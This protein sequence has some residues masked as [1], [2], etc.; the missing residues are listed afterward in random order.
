MKYFLDAI[1]NLKNEIIKMSELAEEMVR[2]S[3]EGLINREPE[4]LQRVYEIEKEVNQMEIKIDN[5]CITMLGMYQPVAKD[6]RFITSAM[7]INNDLERI[8]D[9]AVNIAKNAEF[10]IKQPQLKPYIDLPRMC[11]ITRKMLLDSI[12]SFIERDINLARD[13]LKRDELVD[14][15]NNQIFRELL[16]YMLSDP[17][18]IERAI[19]I[20]FVSHYLERIADLATNLSEDEIYIESGLDVR[21]HNIDEIEDMGKE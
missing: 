9:Q 2:L 6:L 17:K 5:M 14:N 8:G 7:K 1:K 15:L 10:L 20:N 11:D 21:H 13:I 3:V 12:K 4:K 19:A 16:T 18:A